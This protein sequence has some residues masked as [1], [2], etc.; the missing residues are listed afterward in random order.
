MRHKKKIV[1]V[2]WRLEGPGFCIP[3]L[4]L[5]WIVF[6]KL[7]V[8]FWPGEGGLKVCKSRKKISTFIPLPIFWLIWREINKRDSRGFCF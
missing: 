8:F 3:L 2:A 6:D 4:N 7:W 1:H 5:S